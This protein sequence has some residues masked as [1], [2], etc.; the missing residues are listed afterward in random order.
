M[1]VP[2]HYRPLR[3]CAANR[4]RRSRSPD[5][6]AGLEHAQNAEV[7]DTR[8]LCPALEH[9]QDMPCRHGGPEQTSGPSLE[10]MPTGSPQITRGSY[11]EKRWPAALLRAG[12]AWRKSVM[13]RYRPFLPSSPAI[14]QVGSGRGIP[15]AQRSVR[16]PVRTFPFR[17]SSPPCR[18]NGGPRD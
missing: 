1:D 13:L 2:R 11:S 9:G 6:V 12:G 8:D 17:E 14:G 15:E 7:I 10:E 4:K 5:T 18:A 3:V 16:L